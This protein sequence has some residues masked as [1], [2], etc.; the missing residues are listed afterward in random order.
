MRLVTAIF[1]AVREVMPTATLC[2]VGADPPGELIEAGGRGVTVTGWV[3]SPQPYLAGAKLVI[4]PLRQGGGMRVK[5]IEACAAGKA[6]IASDL[7]VE[8]LGLTPGVEFVRANS[9]QEF[10][11]A[12]VDLLDDAEARERLGEAAHQWAQRTQDPDEWLSRYENLYARL[13]RRQGN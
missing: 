13:G 2:I 4:V 3:E 10:T 5:M 7:A 9:D 8:G 1:P 12:V 6:V 11:R